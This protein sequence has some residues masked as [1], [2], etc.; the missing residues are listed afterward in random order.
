MSMPQ[1]AQEYFNEVASQ[2]DNIRK[3]YFTEAVRESAIAKAYLRPEMVT[4]D[5]GAGT[6]FIA[7]GLAPLVQKVFV[8]D[9]SASM[10]DVAKNNLS[11]FGDKIEYR[12]ADGQ[13]L[14]LPDGS[15]DVVFANMYLHHCPDPLSAIR[16]MVRILKP[17][18]RLVITDMD[19]H[20]YQWLKE[21]LADE[22]MG[23]ERSAV[24]EWYQAADL[25]N[26]VVDCTGQSCC[27]ES[28]N[29]TITDQEGRAVS[30]SIFV[31]TGTKRIK[32]QQAVKETYSAA[33]T[34][35]TG[36][37]CSSDQGGC[38]SNDPAKAVE[39]VTYDSGYSPAEKAA[40]PAEAGDF[41]LGCGNPIAMANLKAGE[42]VVDIGSGGGMDSF[43]A[44]SRV[45]ISGKVI[46][47]DMTPAMLERATQ[48]ALK[49]GIKNVEFRRGQAESLPVDDETIDVVMSNCVVNLCEDKGRVFQEAYRVLKPGG[50]LELSD[51][52][53]DGPLPVEVRHD[54]GA[55][56][57][58][59]SGALP[60]AEYLDLISQAGFNVINVRRSTSSGEM[61]GISAYS[62][63]VSARK[64][65]P[66][67]ADVACSSGCNCK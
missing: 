21:E 39:N 23:F 53:T 35:Q 42:V 32:M 16:E 43:L 25:V 51:M 60:E 33:A 57:G 1:S 22:W 14:P 8:L 62:V 36:C 3:G 52:V 15:L 47:V 10:L 17:G 4:A 2:W 12:V 49:S 30:I 7:A 46:G 54:A 66:L 11:A 34:G 18:G 29:N 20:T 26:I 55:W 5:V 9:G 63:I 45:G 24:K 6:G 40:V 48:T 59:L 31:A 61:A 28:K 44:A 37:G 65:N 64:G 41:S 58:C 38:C 27:A 67:A 19:S 13:S 56:A 50:R